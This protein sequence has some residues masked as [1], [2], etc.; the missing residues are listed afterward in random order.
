MSEQK[1]DPVLEAILAQYDAKQNNGGNTQTT[2][3]DLKNYFA[4]FLKEGQKEGK[5]RIRILPSTDGG[6]VFRELYIHEEKVG[7]SKKKLICLEKEY[8]KPCPFCDA[9]KEL[10]STEG[11]TPEMIASDKEIGKKYYPRLTY[12]VKV[13]DRDYESD[14]PKFWRIKH[15]SR[16]TG[17][18]NKIM[19]IIK[20]LGENITDKDNGR[21][22][23]INITRDQNKFPIVSSIM[24]KDKSPL[25]TDPEMEELWLNDPKKWETVYAVKPYE[26]LEIIIRGGEPVFS[27]DQDCF[28]D[29]A[30]LTIGEDKDEDAVDFAGYNK[31]KEETVKES[32]PTTKASKPLVEEDDSL[33]L[34]F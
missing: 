2:K 27:K 18:Y 11:K 14:G 20:E 21:D 25:T 17:N 8:G 28:V 16:N 15:D 5:K 26:Y 10:F 34:P 7:D 19:D 22:L 24:A 13:I 32:K 29:K 1:K 6:S 30:T 9:R 12:V 3:Y 31:P 33:D 23:T 4:I